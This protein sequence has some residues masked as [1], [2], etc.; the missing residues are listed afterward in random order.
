MARAILTL[1]EV[2]TMTKKDFK[3]LAE[4]IKGLPPDPDKREIA[5]AIAKV[6]TD[7]NSRFDWQKFYKACDVL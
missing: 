2:R 3:A 5:R 7:T 4:A 1:M 6:C